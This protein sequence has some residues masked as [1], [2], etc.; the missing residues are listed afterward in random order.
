MGV[1]YMLIKKLYLE[2]TDKC[3]L[4][5]KMCYRRS[6]THN[7]YDISEEMLFKLTDELKTSHSD[8]KEIVIGG[9]GEPTFSKHFKKTLELLKDYQITVTTNGTLIDEE[10]SEYLVKYVDV[11]TISIDGLSD[12]FKEIRGTDLDLI[13]KNIN[14]LNKLKNKF[15]SNT[16]LIDIQFV[17]SEDNLKDVFKVMDLASELGANKFIISNIIPQS[18]EN[19]D[20]I[21]YSRYENKTIR[22]LF[23]KV[24]LHSLHKGIKVDMPNYELKTIRRCSFIEDCSAFICASGDIVPCYR[25]SHDYTEYVFGREK[26]VDKFVFGNLEEDSLLNIWNNPEYSNFRQRIINGLYPS[27]IDCDLVDGCDYASSAKVDCYA[28][29]PSCGDCLWS[30]QFA[31]CP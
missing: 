6:W 12:K 16:P 9:I 24:M 21:L 11:V 30:R 23:D 17:L 10:L 15:S 27:C 8:L 5:C 4:N 26:H 18:E 28:L 14:G 2:L 7:F 3:N 20:N 13:V 31:T 19:K 29:F 25:F 22:S 1:T